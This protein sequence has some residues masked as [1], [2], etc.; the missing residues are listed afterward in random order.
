M[1]YENVASQMLKS[2]GYELY[3]HEFYVENKVK[4]ERNISVIFI[5]HDLHLAKRLCDRIAVMKD[6]KIVELDT[7]ENIFKNLVTVGFAVAKIIDFSA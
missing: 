1:V 5:T 4:K 7:P 6:G 3:F 2:M